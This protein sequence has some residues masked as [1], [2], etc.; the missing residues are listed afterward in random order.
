MLVCGLVLFAPPY[1]KNTAAA[2]RYL[3]PVRVR[4]HAQDTII[5]SKFGSGQEPSMKPKAEVFRVAHFNW[6]P[7][8]EVFGAPHGVRQAVYEGMD[9]SQTTSKCMHLRPTKKGPSMVIGALATHQ[10]SGL[11]VVCGCPRPVGGVAFAEKH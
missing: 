6:F 1:S 11:L 4:L 3:A 10:F 7:G 5:A 9:R 8:H 2:A